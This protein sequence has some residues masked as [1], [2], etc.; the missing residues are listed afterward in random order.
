VERRQTDSSG[1]ESSLLVRAQAAIDAAHRI[2]EASEVLAE[3]SP[4]VR[5][6]A[7]IARCAWCSRFRLHDRWLYAEE[8]PAVAEYANLTHTICDECLQALR[9]S[10]MSV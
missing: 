3:L 8:V 1:I 6:K 7:L 2:R 5:M 4:A 9:D 10:G